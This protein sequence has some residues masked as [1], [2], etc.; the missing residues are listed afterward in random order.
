MSVYS[1]SLNVKSEIAKRDEVGDVFTHTDGL[2]YRVTKKT[3]TVTAVERYFWFHA[4]YD[5]LVERVGG[6]SAPKGI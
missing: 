5:R 1:D 2:R 3:R 4:I 6:P